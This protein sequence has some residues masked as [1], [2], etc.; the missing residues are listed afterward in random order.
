VCLYWDYHDYECV[1]ALR[2]DAL[3]VI[4]ALR[5]ER[6]DLRKDVAVLTENLN[7]AQQIV[8][9]LGKSLTAVRAE[10]DLARDHSEDLMRKLCGSCGNGDYVHE[11]EMYVCRCGDDCNWIPKGDV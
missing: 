9:R 3:D 10:R 5:A 7:G 4:E 2:R 8:D 6:D 11:Y 1:Q